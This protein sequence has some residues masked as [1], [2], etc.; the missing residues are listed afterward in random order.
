MK[1]ITNIECIICGEIVPKEQIVMVTVKVCSIGCR[2]KYKA[3]LPKKTSPTQISFWVTKGMTTEEATA[4]VSS[5]QKTRSPRSV[6]H[7]LAKGH[8]LSE[9]KTK[10]QEVQ[11][12]NGKQNAIKYTPEQRRVNMPFC[13]EYWVKM[14]YMIEEARLI[15]KKNSS[16]ISQAALIKKYGSEEG[17]KKYEAICNDRKKCYSLAGY[18]EKHGQA[19]GT[20]LWSKKFKNR[21]NSRA[22][23][24]FF[25]KIKVHIPKEYK[26]YSVVQ[27]DEYGINDAGTYYYYDFV[28]PDLK[29]CIEF[30]GDYWHCNPVKYSESFYQSQSKKFAKDIW[31]HDAKKQQAMM[32]LRNIHTIVVWESTAAESTSVILKE[33]ENAIKSKNSQ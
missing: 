16:T 21:P 24:E 6:E 33:I 23:T 8:S 31:A 17:L 26:V 14:G 3:S 19:L 2:K 15:T 13:P 32:K 18:I 9:A 22:A 29:L 4:H 27:N 30:H 25:E 5:L 1:K 12:R 20:E 10:V 11:S 28:V 7:W